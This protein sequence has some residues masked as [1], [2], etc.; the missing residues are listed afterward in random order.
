[1]MENKQ[2]PVA[3]NHPHLY[4]WFAFVSKFVDA[5]MQKWP[6]GKGGKPA[7][8][9]APKKKQAPP[10]KKTAEVD[11]DDLF[12]DDGSEPVKIEHKPTK[13]KRVVIAKSILLLEI[14]PA[15]S[16]TN[17]DELKKKIQN[18]IVMDGLMWKDEYSKEPI[19]F[20]IEKLI[21]GLVVEDEKVSPD[22]DI[23]HRLET[24]ENFVQSVD[25]R[26]FNKI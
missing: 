2:Y 23:I 6:E 10:A 22:E 8:Q 9:P 21:M 15:D 7:A 18:E 4:A 11:E 1:M 14:K 20:G 13:A 25:I 19:A 17:L 24:W 3:R 12:A 26:S 16:E 5:V